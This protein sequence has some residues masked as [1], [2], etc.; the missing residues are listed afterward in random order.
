M[1]DRSYE[2]EDVGEVQRLLGNVTGRLDSS[3]G[4][5]REQFARHCFGEVS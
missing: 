3:V 2:V 1:Q 5:R 4:E